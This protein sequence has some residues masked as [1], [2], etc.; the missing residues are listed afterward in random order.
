MISRAEQSRVK[1]QANKRWEWRER[2]QSR[3]Q[4]RER[5]RI[6]SADKFTLKKKKRVDT[7]KIG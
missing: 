6:E 7:W 5:I 3:V 1:K 2:G 4:R